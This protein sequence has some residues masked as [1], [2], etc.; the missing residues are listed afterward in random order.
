PATYTVRLQFVEPG[1][2]AVGERQ[3][4]VLV[5]DREVISGLDVVRE[6]AGAKRALVHE[7]TGVEAAEELRVALVPAEN[8]QQPPVLCGIELVREDGR[9]ASATHRPAD[10]SFDWAAAAPP[11]W[12]ERIVSAL[13]WLPFAAWLR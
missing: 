7:V 6:A 4:N 3:F 10:A 9:Q 11:T 8:A 5:Q 12:T 13:S 1:E 2:A